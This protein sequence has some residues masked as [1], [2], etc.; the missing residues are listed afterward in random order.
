M[1][2]AVGIPGHNSVHR[3]ESTVAIRKGTQSFTDVEEVTV[4][5]NWGTYPIV[6]A[7]DDNGLK[8]V[9]VV[10]F[11]DN[12]SFT[13]SWTGLKSGEISINLSNKLE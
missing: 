1:V 6:Q 7:V 9:P 5:H 4:E 13:A 3:V 2:G 11:T 10:T 12:N 8:F